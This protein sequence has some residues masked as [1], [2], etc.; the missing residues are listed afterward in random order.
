MAPRRARVAPGERHEIGAVNRAIA[1]LAGLAT[2]G[3][4]PRLF[5]TLARHRRLFRPWLR[6]A[7]A[8]M[9]GGV[10]PRADSELIILRVAS[11]CG[12]EYERRHHRRLARAAGLSATE[13]E[14]AHEGPGADGW[15]A[16][17]RLLL[18]AADALHASRDIPDELWAELARE[19]SDRELI[20][21]CM[22]VGHYEMLAMTLNALRVEPDPE[23][24]RAPGRLARRLLARRGLAAKAGG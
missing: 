22:L 6:F 3:P 13:I 9:P 18:A 5:T 12:C 2:G 14:R 17:Q 7:A 20:E 11:N 4:P 16:R 24:A 15:T 10:L 19:L 1:R 8:L 21:L 23:P